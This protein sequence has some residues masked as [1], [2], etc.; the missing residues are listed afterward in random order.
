[1]TAES[2]CLCEQCKR[3]VMQCKE[4]GKS[5]DKVLEELEKELEHD[6]EY[7]ISISTKFCDRMMEVERAKFWLRRLKDLRSRLKKKYRKEVAV[8]DALELVED[9]VLAFQRAE[10]E[11]G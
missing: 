2:P 4:R 11:Q 3:T 6:I 7:Q 9:E 1:M 10:R 5:S 8:I